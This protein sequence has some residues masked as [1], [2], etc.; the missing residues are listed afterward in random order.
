M[1]T[2]TEA[3]ERV[4]RADLRVVP[5]DDKQAPHEALALLE[6][7]HRVAEDTMTSARAEAE[8]LLM[9]ARHEAQQLRKQAREQSDRELTETSRKAETARAQAQEEADRLLAEARNQITEIEQERE[10]VR[11]AQESTAQSARELAHKLLQVVES[12]PNNA[13]GSNEYS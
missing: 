3:D 7:A 10:R 8:R 13:S 6:H 11:G 5:P 1:A 2:E 9:A 4:D 12:E